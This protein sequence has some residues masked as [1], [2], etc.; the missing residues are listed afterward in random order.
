MITSLLSANCIQ[1]QTG[2]HFSNPNW[3][4]VQTM[5]RINKKRQ[6]KLTMVSTFL[7]GRSL[8]GACFRNN[9]DKV[10]GTCQ[11]LQTAPNHVMVQILS[12]CHGF[13]PHS[14]LF[15]ALMWFKAEQDSTFKCVRPS[16]IP[17]C[18]YLHKETS[19]QPLARTGGSSHRP[20]LYNA[21]YRYGWRES[22]KGHLV[23]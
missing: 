14:H 20:L 3:L 15:S 12:L 17:L 2:E 8:L 1:K 11:Y 4:R 13:R 21:L 18:K 7:R 6:L 9:T 23:R 5:S 10:I 22:K 16:I 19:L